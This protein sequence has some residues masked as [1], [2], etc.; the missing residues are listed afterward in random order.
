MKS[1]VSL[2]AALVLLF[3]LEVTL[4]AHALCEVNSIQMLALRNP[5]SPPLFFY[6]LFL[7]IQ[8]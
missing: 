4:L 5:I 6:Y 8:T 7:E 3:P 2:L 1:V